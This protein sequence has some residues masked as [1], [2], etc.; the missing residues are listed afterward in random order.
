MENK[1]NSMQNN[2]PNENPQ[3]ENDLIPKLWEEVKKV[4][5]PEIGLSIVDLGLV[6]DIWTEG[7]KAFVKMTLT[8]MGCPAG[9]FL[10]HEVKEACKRI[11]GI[12]EASVEITFSPTWDP[13]E[14][15]SEEVKMMLGIF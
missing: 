4:Y 14:M 10:E 15:A 11:E 3:T 13:R 9:P 7:N 5:D 12:Q 8:S 6:Y 1:E 2:Q